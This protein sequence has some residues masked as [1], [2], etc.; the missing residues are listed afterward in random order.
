MINIDYSIGIMTID[1]MKNSGY[2]QM[3]ERVTVN[4]DLVYSV[5]KIL[6]KFMQISIEFV[7]LK[8]SNYF[9]FYQNERIYNELLRAFYDNRQE[10]KNV[11]VEEYN[12]NGIKKELLIS[13]FSKM[14]KHYNI[15]S[16]AWFQ[17]YFDYY[18]E[19]N[20]F[21]ICNLYE[22]TTSYY[23]IKAEEGI[24]EK[25]LDFLPENIEKRRKE[26]RQ[27]K[28]EKERNDKQKEEVKRLELAETLLNKVK[29][30][31]N[32][33]DEFATIKDKLNLHNEVNNDKCLQEIKEIDELKQYAKELSGKYIS[34]ETCAY[35][36][37]WLTQTREF[38][39]TLLI[40][41][42]LRLRE[43]EYGT[44]S[45]L[46]QKLRSSIYRLGFVELLDVYRDYKQCYRNI[47]EKQENA[48]EFA[49]ES[50]SLYLKV[51][52]YGAVLISN[53]MNQLNRNKV[54]T[55]H[56]A[57]EVLDGAMCFYYETDNISEAYELQK[58]E[59]YSQEK[60]SGDAGERKVEYTLQWLDK[61]F[62]N[63]EARSKNYSGA[64]CIK[65]SN[66]LFINKIQEYD[67]IVIGP[68]GVFVIETKNFSGIII[69]DKY[70][71]WIRRRHDEEVGMI[72]PLQQMRQHEKVLKSFLPESV[73]VVSILCIANDKAII[74]GSENFSL[75]IVKS[76]MLVEFLEN[77]TADV[78][79][80]H[81]DVKKLSE[82]I[83]EHMVN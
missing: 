42:E 37:G 21:D 44:V 2:S 52:D 48:D 70:G 68:K 18:D 9:F 74:E 4:S 20:S 10:I 14:C 59:Q 57:P 26:I 71:N 40:E 38:L 27:E 82:L 1:V 64:S 43:K 3:Q 24:Y 47:A 61:S 32:P 72:N 66:P 81:E 13:C 80:T 12:K 39:A 45:S 25:L 75:P 22:H 6:L 73:N 58:K 50:Y 36:I 15:Q 34:E 33:A 60:E 67:H 54:K 65:L 77:Y 55:K 63:I 83:Y 28:A 49:A 19:L 8:S 76:D 79:M 29:K 16:Y 51:Y 31:Y 53:K 11:L 46:K 41:D 62:V 23:P 5:D 30:Y 69:V 35:L 17:D 56:I 7:C 78:I